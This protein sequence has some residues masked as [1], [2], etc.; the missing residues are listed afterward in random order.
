MFLGLI[1]DVVV[2]KSSLEASS[3]NKSFSRCGDLDEKQDSHSGGILA[4]V[5]VRSVGDFVEVDLD[6]FLGLIRDVGVVKSSLE[7]SGAETNQ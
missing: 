4:V 6:V 1:R 2:V 5:S 7:A 3:T